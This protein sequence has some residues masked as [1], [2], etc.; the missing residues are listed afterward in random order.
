[1][2]QSQ[3]VLFCIVCY[4]H[5]FPN[6]VNGCLTEELMNDDSALFEVP[7]ICDCVIQSYTSNDGCTKIVQRALML[8][9]FVSNAV[10]FSHTLKEIH[11]HVECN[12]R[13]KPDNN[14]MITGSVPHS[15]CQFFMIVIVRLWLRSNGHKGTSNKTGRSRKNELRTKCM[16][17]HGFPTIADTLVQRCHSMI[18]KQNGFRLSHGY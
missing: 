5:T 10:D 8:L 16:R 12:I 4:R 3:L 9:K 15:S 18:S 13:V 7:G 11:I 17:T 2:F 1:M 6:T 14:Q